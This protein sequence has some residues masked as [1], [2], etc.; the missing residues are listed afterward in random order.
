VLEESPIADLILE[1]VLTDNQAIS[2]VWRAPEYWRVRRDG[3]SQGGPA[4]PGRGTVRAGVPGIRPQN[5]PGPCC[6]LFS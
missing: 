5:R 2:G 1:S 6:A 4:Y 3:V